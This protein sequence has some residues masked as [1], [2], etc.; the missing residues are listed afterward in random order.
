MN[1]PAHLL[2][3]DEP[4]GVIDCNGAGYVVYPGGNHRVAALL[5]IET[6]SPGQTVCAKV[7]HRELPEGV[8]ER[9]R[10]FTQ[11]QVDRIYKLSQDDLSS[12]SF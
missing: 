1:T 8:T 12:Y 10:D 3:S 6:Y 7:R 4:I 9:I 5:A 2:G 11:E